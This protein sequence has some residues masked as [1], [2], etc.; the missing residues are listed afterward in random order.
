MCLYFPCS[1]IIRYLRFPDFH[2]SARFLLAKRWY[3]ESFTIRHGR[4]G[5]ER[6]FFLSVWC[7]TSFLPVSNDMISRVC[8]RWLS[9]IRRAGLSSDIHDR[10]S[11]GRY[12][13]QWLLGPLSDRIGRRPVMLAGVVW[14]IVTCGDPLL[15]KTSNKFYLPAFLQGISLKMFYRRC[16]ACR[17]SESFVR[18]RCV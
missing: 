3:A 1:L 7:C 14:F 10:L 5:S 2:Y 17:Y 18:K 13:A 4:L 9:S 16:R 6:C 12:V 8:W 15:A 11:G